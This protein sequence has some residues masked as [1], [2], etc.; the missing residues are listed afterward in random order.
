MSGFSGV[1]FW[2]GLERARHIPEPNRSID[3]LGQALRFGNVGNTGTLAEHLPP[4]PTYSPQSPQLY[5]GEVLEDFL[6]L[7][8]CGFRKF[9]VFD[10]K[11]DLRLRRSKNHFELD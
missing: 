7:W 2:A 10:N 6:F 5:E 4:I 1:G 11:K 8:I 3:R 9:V